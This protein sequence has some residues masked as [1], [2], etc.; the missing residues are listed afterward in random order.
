MSVHCSLKDHDAQTS[1]CLSN[2]CTAGPLKTIQTPAPPKSTTP[3]LLVDTSICQ[4]NPFHAV[5][6][7]EPARRALCKH[8][9]IE[10]AGAQNKIR[11]SRPGPK[12]EELEEEGEKEK[13][14]EFTDYAIKCFEKNNL[15]DMVVKRITNYKYGSTVTGR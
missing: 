4:N 13:E 9:K 7:A 12:E 1:S 11:A 6:T 2:S 8:T 10:A 5:R 14:Y 15:L 3:V